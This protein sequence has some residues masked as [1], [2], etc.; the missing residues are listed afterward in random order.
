MRIRKQTALSQMEHGDPTHGS[1][2]ETLATAHPKEA[3]Q[4][5]EHNNNTV[6]S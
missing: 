6:D 3:E 4:L 1:R 5:G 2:S